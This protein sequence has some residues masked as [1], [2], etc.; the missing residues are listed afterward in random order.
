MRHSPLAS[1]IAS[2]T[3]PSTSAPSLRGRY[4]LHRYYGPIRL[5]SRPDLS[6]AG[7][8]LAAAATGV[9]LPCC[10]I[11]LADV[12]SPLPRRTRRTGLFGA[13]DGPLYATAAAFP[14]CPRGRH[15]HGIVS[16]PARRSV[17]LRPI[18]LLS[19]LC[20]PFTSEASADSLPPRLFRLLPGGTNNLPGR[21]FHP[22]ENDTFSRRTDSHLFRFF[23]ARMEE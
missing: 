9:G 6:L 23:L 10:V 14:L 4:P 2:C 20:D 13:F 16:R 19:R 18:C 8:Q 3:D 12:P 21:D 5:P 1:R 17:L 15:P 11:F 7:V 22:L